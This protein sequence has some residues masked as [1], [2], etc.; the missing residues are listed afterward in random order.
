MST[1]KTKKTPAVS[2]NLNET[3]TKIMPNPIA[4]TDRWMGLVRANVVTS[5]MKKFFG[6]VNLADQKAM[7]LIALNSLIIP[8]VLSQMNIEDFK[9]AS[10]IS[11]VTCALSMFTAMICIFPKRRALGK[12]DGSINP[13]HFS[14]VAR[15]TESEYLNI[16]RPIYNNPSL[17]AETV[18]KDLHDVARYIL[19]PKFFWLK[20]S[21]MIFFFGNLLAILVELYNLW[22]NASL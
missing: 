5:N 18:I 17:L 7:G 16:M 1:K 22:G 14:D 8:I 9:I 21:Y 19:R 13:L 2:S 11:I 3:E 4:D 15:L 12:P 6:Y 20:L 10:T